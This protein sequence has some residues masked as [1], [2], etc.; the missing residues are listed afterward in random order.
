MKF[1]SVLSSQLWPVSGRQRN[2][3]FQH[4]DP[5][6]RSS[7][8][9]VFQQSL[10]RLQ[11]MMQGMGAQ[12]VSNLVWSSAKLGL[13]PDEHVPGM[14]HTSTTRFLQLM[15]ATNLRQLPKAR[16]TANQLWA[17]A[18][19]RYAATKELVDPVCSHFATVLQRSS[20]RQRP[21]G[22]DIANVIWSLGT[23]EH[24]PK[25][26]DF[27]DN[28]CMYMHRLLQSQDLRARPSAQQVTN[29]LWAL[30]KLKHSLKDVKLLDDF[31][32]Y[33]HRLGQSKDLRTRPNAQDITNLFWA[34]SHLQMK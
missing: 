29:V 17:L 12:T 11:P 2:R 16:D 4:S 5:K 23:L 33:M 13:K 26:V 15:H 25:D 14:V 8:E 28:S 6:L 32:M 34:L 19:M 18:T 30:A 10:K 27:L 31:C 20:T 21:N 24:A 7:V 3:N 22:L 9:A 1:T